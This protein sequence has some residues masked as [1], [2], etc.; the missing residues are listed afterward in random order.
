MW[1]WTGQRGRVNR[2]NFARHDLSAVKA[3]DVPTLAIAGE[4]DL[5]CPPKAVEQVGTILGGTFHLIDGAG[6]SP[7]F[8]TPDEWNRVVLDWLATVP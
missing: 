2:P 1:R 8:E 3:L 5:L 4:D 7:Y 6:H